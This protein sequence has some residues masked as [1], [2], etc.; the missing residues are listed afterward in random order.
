M[1]TMELNEKMENSTRIKDYESQN[2]L[3]IAKINNINT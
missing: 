2:K 3:K 1:R